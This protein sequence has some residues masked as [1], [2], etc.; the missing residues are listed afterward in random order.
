MTARQAP[1]LAAEQGGRRDDVPD[2]EPAG[3]TGSNPGPT[4]GQWLRGLLVLA[5][6]GAWAVLAH[7][8]SAGTAPSDFSTLLGVAPIVAALGL[9]VWRTGWPLLTAS[10]G[11]ALLGGLYWL[12][13][14]LRQNV[15]LL[16]F[17]QHLGAN[18]A[19]AALFGR[20][21]LGPGEALVTGMARIV[22]QGEV[23]ERKARYTRQVTIAWTL[24]FV[25]NAL[26]SAALYLLAPPA[27]WSSFANLLSMPLILAMFV[28]EHLVRSRVLPPEERPSIAQVVRAYRMTHRRNPPR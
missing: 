9:L 27:V 14:I 21:L 18:L 6:V 26:L 11:I 17:L 10:S 3:T 24:F 5:A 1:P 19:L 16:Y 23:S 12:W 2:T 7:R 20:S 25:A 22:H 13:P 4:P 28:G 15:A 8:G